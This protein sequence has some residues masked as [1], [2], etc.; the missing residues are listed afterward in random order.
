M[1]DKRYNGIVDEV[2]FY[3]E[4]SKDGRWIIP[5][6]V[7]WDYTLTTC[8]S[9]E[10]GEM[11]LNE[12]AFP[13]MKRWIEEYN[14]GFILDT[15]RHDDILKEPLKILKEK[16]IELYGIRKN[17]QQDKDGNSV[18]KVFAVFSI[19]DR[20]IGIPNK[21]DDGCTRPHVD[22][23]KVDEI[24]TPILEL[25]ASNLKKVVL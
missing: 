8:S 5:I 11:T 24:M 3:S 16:N 22:W 10:T 12:E 13:I 15:M 1:V 6:A 4:R 9:W 17:P 7:D 25:I 21:W 20:N 2:L 23:K 18:P 14:V 19:D